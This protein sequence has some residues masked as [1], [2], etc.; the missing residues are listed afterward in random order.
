[1]RDFRFTGHING[2][3]I[4]VTFRTNAITSSDG[5]FVIAQIKVGHQFQVGADGPGQT[6]GTDEENLVFQKYF[7]GVVGTV[8]MGPGANGEGA[9][10]IFQKTATS[11]A[12]FVAFA[13]ANNLSLAAYDQS[14]NKTEIVADSSESASGSL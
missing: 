11:R 3:W 8:D 9:K 14:G 7:A 6:P 2:T 1:M 13:L 4:D 12:E 5:A 10:Q